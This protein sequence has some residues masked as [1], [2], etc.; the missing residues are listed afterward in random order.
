MA[1]NKAVSAWFWTRS[2]NRTVVMMICSKKPPI[3]A[4]GL[5]KWYKFRRDN[6][7]KE[8]KN[9]TDS[10]CKNEFIRFFPNTYEKL[11]KKPKRFPIRIGR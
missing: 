6:K 2:G 5:V 9:H 7:D 4:S 10:Y 1:K 8:P 11:T 3:Y